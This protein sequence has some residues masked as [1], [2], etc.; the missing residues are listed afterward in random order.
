MKR[1]IVISVLSLLFLI[2]TFNAQELNS[3]ANHIRNNY[4]TDYEATLR[5]HA[6]EKWGDDYRMVVYEINQQADALVELVKEFKSENTNIAF[7]AIQKWSVEGYK[8]S[9]TEQFQEMEVFGLKQLIKMHC[10]WRMV[11][12]EYDRQVR[13]KDAF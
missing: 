7:R 13:A 3:N 10:D 6:L 8:N 12:Y 4:S 2:N 5:K 11:K 1:I 9:N